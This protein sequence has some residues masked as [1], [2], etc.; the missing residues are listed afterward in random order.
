MT[1]NTGGTWCSPLGFLVEFSLE[2]ED[3][4]IEYWFQKGDNFVFRYEVNMFQNYYISVWFI[5][6]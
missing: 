2:G 1:V 4:G 5:C 6:S 3:T